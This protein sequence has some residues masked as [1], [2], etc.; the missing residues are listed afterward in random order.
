MNAGA[1]RAVRAATESD[2]TPVRLWMSFWLAGEAAAKDN[3]RTALLESHSGEAV[4]SSRALLMG[5]SKPIT[6]PSVR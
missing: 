2:P 3:P 1:S 6:V 4:S 5:H